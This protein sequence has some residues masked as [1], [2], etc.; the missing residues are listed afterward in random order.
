MNI[1]ANECWVGATGKE[2]GVAVELGR[3]R[4]HSVAPGA[5]RSQNVLSRR[6]FAYATFADNHVSHGGTRQSAWGRRLGREGDRG[7]RRAAQ[8]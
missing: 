4:L 3:Q 5:A 2:A 6:I 8:G 1:A 7:R